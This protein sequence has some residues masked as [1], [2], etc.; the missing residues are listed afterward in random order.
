M[1]GNLGVGLFAPHQPLDRRDGV[2][3]VGHRLALGNLAHQRLALAGKGDHRRRGSRT[4]R[5]GNDQGLQSLDDCY[6]RVGRAEI[7]ADDSAHGFK[8]SPSGVAA[9]LSAA[10]SSS[11]GLATGGAEATT[12]MAGRSSFSPMR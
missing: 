12:T 9:G 3:G 2:L 6:A 4:L 1:P 10:A 7:D 5:I 11:I 8:S